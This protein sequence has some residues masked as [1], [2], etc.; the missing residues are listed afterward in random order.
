MP[1]PISQESARKLRVIYIPRT[2]KTPETL[3]KSFTLITNQTSFMLKTMEKLIKR[4]IRENN[5]ATNQKDPH[6]FVSG[7]TKF[8]RIH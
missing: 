6:N 8:I 7:I 3:P 2:G 1:G 4:Y 5:M